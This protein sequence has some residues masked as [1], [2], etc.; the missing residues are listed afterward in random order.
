MTM[1]KIFSSLSELNTEQLMKVYWE[2]NQ[3]NGAKRHPD[4]GFDYQRQRA[5]DDFLRYLSEDFFL[6]KD[7][8]YAV[9]LHDKAYVAAL[10]FEPY[11]DGLLI[12][13]L[14]TSPHERRKGYAYM[15]LSS[16]LHYL[17][18]TLYTVVYSHIHKGNVASLAVH[19]K[20]G[21]QKESE[22][23][24]YIDGTITHNSCTMRVNL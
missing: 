4:C 22:F 7:A 17:K 14:E 21:F 19:K 24:K 23:A 10:R 3:E 13:A 18:T 2:Y 5:E 11:M 15:L 20:C 9:W 12:E 8:Q 6:H 1:L 16:T